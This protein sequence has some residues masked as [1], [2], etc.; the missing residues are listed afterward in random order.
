MSSE[1]LENKVE[2]VR[3]LHCAEGHLRGIATM[4][5]RGADCRS[6]VC[7]ILAVQAALRKINSLI[8][9]YHLTLCLRDHWSETGPDATGRE[10]WLAE[11]ISLYQLLGGSL[12]PL[13]GKEAP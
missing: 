8:V 3:R 10:Y 1:S 6:L 13:I 11:V 9:K 4:V 2:L 7:Q 5:E 12:P